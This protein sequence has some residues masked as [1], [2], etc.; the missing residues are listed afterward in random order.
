MQFDSVIFSFSR[1]QT[2]HG[3][4]YLKYTEIYVEQRGENKK[5]GP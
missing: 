4:S 2:L 1:L 5:A 3:P